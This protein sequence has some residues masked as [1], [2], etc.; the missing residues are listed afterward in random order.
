MTDALMMLDTQG[1]IKLANRAA[2]DA[3]EVPESELIGTNFESYVLQKASVKPFLDEIFRLGKSVTQELT[4]IS[5]SGK[6]ILVQVSGSSVVDNMKTTLGFV[7]V[8]RDI[9]VLKQT[10]VNLEQRNMELKESQE[11][12]KSL[13]EQEKKAR[14]ELEEEAKA[15]TQFIDVLAHELRTPL[16]PI[17]L[18]A[19]MLK[20]LSPDPNSAQFKLVN[21]TL[22]GAQ[23]LKNRLEELLDM[24]RFTRGAFQLKPQLMDPSEFLANIALR[25]Q[26]AV[27]Q[28]QQQLVIQIPN[29]L[30]QVEADPSRLEQ[31][32]LNL[33]SNA[34]K[35]SPEKTVITYEASI[36]NGSVLVEVKDQG[37][38]ITPED[39][40]SLFI[41][42][43]RVAQDRKSYMGIGL[44]LAVSKQIVEA[45]GG[46]IWVDSESGKGCTFKFTLPINTHVLAAESANSPPV[47]EAARVGRIAS[48]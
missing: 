43:H 18:G 15:K 20:E 29:D 31:V 34:S 5:R 33:L 30:P 23:S 38:G 45:H 47:Y 40:K 22:S 28:K 35:Y 4:Y 41:P 19:E 14:I 12:V 37:I 3:I 10:E 36:N 16:T 9:T 6:H 17:L 32:V 24:A 42:Y 39:Q 2:V 48:G 7:V 25:Y 8:A 11:Q 21:N 27:E 26:P 46:K 13:Y 44:G 1:I